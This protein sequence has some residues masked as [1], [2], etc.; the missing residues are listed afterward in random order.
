MTNGGADPNSKCVFPFIY[1]GNSY[2]ICTRFNDPDNIAWCSTLVDAN[3]THV[4]EQGKW[5]HCGAG[6]PIPPDL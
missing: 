1:L 4:G 5:G 6:C 2:D 3:G